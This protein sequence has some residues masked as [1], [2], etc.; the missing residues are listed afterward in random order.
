M[1]VS[2]IDTEE[3]TEAPVPLVALLEAVPELSR[4]V[5]ADEAPRARRAVTA[6]L[7]TLPEGRFDPPQALASGTRPFA[8]LVLS[9]LVARELT[10]GGQPTLRL[11]GPGDVIHGAPLPSGLLTPEEAYTATLPT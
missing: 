7:L 4:H 9:G 1:T 6:P 5:T 11:L 2:R 10:V 8:A 3:A